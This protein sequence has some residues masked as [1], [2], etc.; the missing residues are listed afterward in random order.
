MATTQLEKV[1]ESSSVVPS[2]AA[3]SPTRP[4]LSADSPWTWLLAVSLLVL[5]S[6]GIRFWREHQFQ[7][8]A[9]RSATCPFPLKDLP[10]RG[11]GGMPSKEP[12]C[13]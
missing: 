11:K 3:N 6:G 1:A 4:R 2:A 8:L 9:D 13:S 5:I 7:L 10:E 12:P